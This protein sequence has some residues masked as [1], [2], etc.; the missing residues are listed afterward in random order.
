MVVTRGRTFKRPWRRSCLSSN[1]KSSSAPI[2][3][4]DSWCFHAVGSSNAP[5]LGSTAAEGLPRIGRTSIATRWR[6]CGLP[7]SAS[8]SENF[9]IPPDVF[10]QTLRAHGK[11]RHGN[12]W[13]NFSIYLTI[14]DQHLREIEALMLRIASPPGAKMQGRLAQSRD[15][16]RSITRAIKQKQSRE[17]SSLF[18]K[19][20]VARAAERLAQ[21]SNHHDPDLIRL[22]PLGARLR[23][24]HRGKTHKARV[25]RDGTIRY[26]GKKYASLSEAG[27]AA[28]KRSTNGWWFWQVERGKGNWVRL[29]KIRRAGTPVYSR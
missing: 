10:G 25:R 18:I 20:G 4:K 27:K 1:L 9:V 29:T 22:L 12:V 23:G 7:Q 26:N 17:V 3:R 11:N 8:C 28:L 16:R 24:T 15:M 5:L 19:L 21:E 6:S 14:K 13:D 2:G